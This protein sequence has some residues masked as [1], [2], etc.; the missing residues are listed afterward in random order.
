MKAVNSVVKGDILMSEVIPDGQAVNTGYK[1][2][3]A[4]RCNPDGPC[5]TC[6]GIGPKQFY[7]R[8]KSGVESFMMNASFS[9]PSNVSIYAD[10]D[11][12]NFLSDKSLIY[13]ERMESGSESGSKENIFHLCRNGV[14]KGT[15]KKKGIMKGMNQDYKGNQSGFWSTSSIG[16]TGVL[17]LEFKKLPPVELTLTIKDNQITV[18]GDRYFVADT[19]K[20]K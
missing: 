15:I 11:W 17:K 4:A 14:F 13:L 20:C 1:G 5:I 6:L 9:A 2:F 8:I 3:A 10:F 12:K 18:N 19:D 7:D 16:D